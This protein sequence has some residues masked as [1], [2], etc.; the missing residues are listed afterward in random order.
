MLSKY[1]Y[2]KQK[3]LNYK[4]KR[5]LDTNTE[6][7]STKKE[8]KIIHSPDTTEF[9]LFDFDFDINER[10]NISTSS[11]NSLRRELIPVSDLNKIKRL[12]CRADILQRIEENRAEQLEIVEAEPSHTYNLRKRGDRQT[13]KLFDGMILLP[14][15]PLLFS[16]S[17]YERMETKLKDDMKLIQDYENSLDPEYANYGKEYGKIVECWFADT[18]V[19]PC[20]SQLTLKRYRSNNFPIIDLVCVNPSHNVVTHGVKFFQVKASNGAPFRGKKYFSTEGP[21]YYI[22]TGSKRFGEHIHSITANNIIDKPYTIGYICISIKYKKNQP[23][24]IKRI[25]YIL[26]NLTQNNSEYY[27]YINLDSDMTRTKPIITWN[28]SNCFLISNSPENLIV[29][30]NYL[31]LSFYEIIP[32]PLTNEYQIQDDD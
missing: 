15:T 25:D 29:E 9:N 3:Y 20:C 4:T 27:R 1:L 31:N 10:S 2:Y 16:P 11:L 30:H 17:T 13:R 22:Q 24:L 6:E 32:N 28:P 19:C 12:F 5:T 7:L 21:E 23:I 8:T 18:Q 26:P 14:Q